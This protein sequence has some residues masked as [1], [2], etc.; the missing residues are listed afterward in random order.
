MI[1]L[2]LFFCSGATAL[3]YEVI[4]S[5]Y[6]TLLFG[7]TIQAQTVVLAVF[8]GG[9]ALGN[10]LFG[11]RADRARQPL[12]LYGYL[13]VAV[14]LY[15]F[16]FSSI[17]KVADGVF[18]AAGARLL[19]HN[20]WLL[21]LKGLLSAALLLGPTIL[22]GG[23]LPVLAAW[24]Q[25]STTDAGRRSAR[26][27]STNSLGAVCGAWLAGFCLV[28]WL[29]LPVT[30][31]MTALVN[32]LIGLTALGI[33]RRRARGSAEPAAAAPAAEEP[34]PVPAQPQTA[35]VLFRLGC[36]LVALTGAVSMGLEVLASRCLVL[37]FGASL[38]AFAIVLMAFI[39]GIG[40]GSAVM[41]SPRRK[42]WPKELTTITLVLGAA[43]WLGLLVFN[44]EGLVEL[45]R[46]ARSGLN[47]STMG[48]R[49]YQVMA[50]VFSIFVL[51]LPAAALGSVLPLWIRVVSGTSMLLGDR[52]GR[53]LT[54]NTLGAVGGVLLTGFVLMP[55]FGLRGSFTALA[56]V[57]SGAALFLA[58]ARQQRLAAA[59]A[60]LISGLLVL[61]A[62]TGGEGWRLVLGSG[63]FRLRETE[64]SSV[65]IRQDRKATRLLF[66]EDAADATVSVEENGPPNRR[67]LVL[68]V[69]GKADASTRGDWS[70]QILVAHLPL[71]V[72]PESR[73]VFVF[74]MG[75]G[76]SAGAVLGYPVQRLTVAE[77]CEPVLR[78]AKLF[79]AWNQ[80]VLTNGRTHLC[81]ED[82]RTVLKL[83]PHKY[84]V[85]I[86][87][88]SNPWTAG[89]GSV[90]SREFY[91]LAASRLQPGGILAQWFHLYEM[92]D[93]IVDLVVRTFG[94]VFPNME[95]WDANGGDI[96][97]LGSP[98]PWK[99]DRET[100]ERALALAGPR[101]QLAE[102][103]LTTPGAI[104][105]RQFAS[106]RTAF[107]VTGPGPI[108]TDDF[109]LLE[110]A[111]PRAFFIGRTAL[112]LHRFDER[113]WQAGLGPAEKDALVT[114]LSEVALKA[115]FGGE[116]HSV[117]PDLQAYVSRRW[118]GRLGADFEPLGGGLTL[119]S[120]FSPTNRGA[121]RPPPAAATN[122]IAR[123][124]F[125]AEV[126][127][128]SGSPGQ[129]QALEQILRILQAT[130]GYQPQEAG[131]SVTYYVNLAVK[132]SVRRGDSQAA[133]KIV[134]RGLQLEPNSEVTQYLAR[135]MVRAGILEPGEVPLASAEQ[136]GGGEV[137]VR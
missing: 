49:Y 81:R 88:P 55:N 61:V 107:A 64:V 128:Q 92:S 31:Q 7:S 118:E 126:A 6:L 134:L 109:P 129:A 67:Q 69:N 95:I 105:A 18:A 2:L 130:Q 34:N 11:S 36:V 115:V 93:G 70:T 111:A 94:T 84:D 106:Q 57:L 10:R 99:S 47:S 53:L 25:K 38:Q 114:G 127:L 30:L 74:G 104:L 66:Y 13:E 132:A 41:A 80:G 17:Y 1:I 15:A 39:L 54:W 46:H 23:T 40:V 86:A 21:S 71:M 51:G 103:G 76:I 19:D 120:I 110:Y 137:S 133:K 14:G 116:F 63:A 90:F 135:V 68:R 65:S 75:S 43:A 29:G 48:Y 62:A 77:N 101:R 20:G 27:Y 78:A 52:V 122:E 44:I 12:A 98:Q 85:I 5:K 131:W 33:A 123:R 108:Q 117:N 45:Y 28:T 102:I 83:S 42:E 3:V 91:R 73:D 97:L 82:A 32:V 125:E 26:F 100:F 56:L 24:L 113:T 136:V 119:P 16:F 112:L 8:M 60:G 72:K 79:A 89:I 35:S 58:W 96:I 4:W 37:I 124:L 50:A 87:E 22:M 121:L 9:L 59:A